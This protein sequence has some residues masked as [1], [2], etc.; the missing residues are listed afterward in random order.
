MEQ[1]VSARLVER[2]NSA[3]GSKEHCTD[4]FLGSWAHGSGLDPNSTHPCRPVGPMT[5]TCCVNA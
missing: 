4:M 2:P 5:L 3:A 1:G